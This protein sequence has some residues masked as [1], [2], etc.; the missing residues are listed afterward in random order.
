MTQQAANGGRFSIDVPPWLL[1][2]A[3]EVLE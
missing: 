2:T 3:E 1:A